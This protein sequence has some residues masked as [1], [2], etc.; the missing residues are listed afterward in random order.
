MTR[1]SQIYA[2]AAIVKI[3]K[4]AIK[5]LTFKQE[6]SFGFVDFYEVWANNERIFEVT[7]NLNAGKGHI[8][9]TT[10]DNIYPRNSDFFISGTEVYFDS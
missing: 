6:Y 4:V 9:E 7:V 2:A 10:A 5:S 3:T 1:D 8:K